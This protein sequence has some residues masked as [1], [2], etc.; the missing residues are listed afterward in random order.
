MVFSSRFSR[1]L[2]TSRQNLLF[3]ETGIIRASTSKYLANFLPLSMTRPRKNIHKGN[4]GISTHQHIRF[5]NILSFQLA[6]PRYLVFLFGWARGGKLP[7]FWRRSI[8]RRFI[9]RPPRWTASELP[10]VA[11]PIAVSP[12]GIRQRWEIMLMQRWWIAI[13]AG[14]SSASA[15]FFDKF[16]VIN[17]FYPSVN[18][19][20]LTSR[21]GD[22]TASGS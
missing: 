2:D 11:V 21:A 17:L 6:K 3:L 16:S 8:Q 5:Q 15:R 18:F 12:L 19:T 14:Y 4:L 9:A 7:S 10:V 22:Y 20:P 13:M 1:I